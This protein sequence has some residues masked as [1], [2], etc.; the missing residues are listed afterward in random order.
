[1]EGTTINDRNPIDACS[2]VIQGA[3]FCCAGAKAALAG[4]EIDF[5]VAHDLR[6]G[7]D[8]AGII[9]AV[10]L[11]H[12]TNLKNYRSLAVLFPCTPSLSEN[13]FENFLWARLQALHDIDCHSFPWD[14]SVSNNPASPEFAF[15]IGAQAYYVVG[16]HPAAS[17]ISRRMPFPVIAFNTH[18]Q[19]RRLRADGNFW[20]VQ[21][22]TRAREIA[23]Q[24]CTNPMLAEHGIASEAR[25]YSGREITE[26]WRCPFQPAAQKAGVA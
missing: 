4:A 19:F 15:S 26:H 20:R 24:G 5:F 13:E 25:Q 12:T 17:R 10:R 22:V 23:L 11:F 6:C 7:V 1:M 18:A 14:P 16:M 21:K 9:E 2:Q 3:S 8:D